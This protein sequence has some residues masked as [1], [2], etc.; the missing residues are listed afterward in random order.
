MVCDPS[1][2]NINIGTP[3]PSPFIP[4]L[5][6]PFS[7]PKLPLPDVK[8]PPGIPEDIIDLV[9]RIVALFPQG[10]KLV[11]NADKFMK[12]VWEA[13]AKIFDQIAP[14]LAFYKFIQALLNIILCIIDVI[15]ALFSPWATMKAVKRM[16][17]Q[18]LPD[19]LSLFP[20][21]ALLV[22]ILALILLLIEIIEYLIATI[23][24]YINQIIENIKILTRAIQ[25]HDADST[26]A[27]INK[28]AYI[29]CMIEQLFAILLAF[30]AII[31]II[32]PLMGMFGRPVC[33]KG[34]SGEDSCCSEDFCPSFISNNPEGLY[35]K[36]GHL[37]YHTEILPNIPTDPLF[38]WMHDIDVPPQRP[39]R[40]QFVDDVVGT[41]DFADIII[42]SPE[43]GFTFWPE[44]E[45]Y[46]SDS[47]IVRVPYLLDMNI[48]INPASYG[49]PSDI[50][51]TRIFNIR[52]I[53]V[54]QKPAY[55]ATQWN[56]VV[57][58]GTGGT[59]ALMLCGGT[60]WEY[61]SDGY[62]QYFI[63]SNAATLETLITKTNPATAIPP[64]DDGYNFT[65]L[66]Y[67]LRWNHAVLIDKKL[68]GL[69][70]AP[71]MALE[72]AVFNAEFSD[73]RSVL[74]RV[75]DLPDIGTLSSDRTTGTGTLGCLARALTKFRTNLNEESALVFQAEM[76]ACLNSLKDD[77]S[78]YF[79]RGTLAA[80]DKF[81]DDFELD[82]EIQFVTNSIDVTV[83]LRDKTGTLLASNVPENIG[84]S[85]ASNIKATPTLG[86]VTDFYYDGYDSFK[87]ILTSEVA[88]IGKI[89]AY[90]NNEALSEVLNRDDDTMATEI[91]IRELSY[92]FVDHTTGMAGSSS[93][94][95]G[96]DSTRAIRFGNS[97]I[98][99]DS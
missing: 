93:I 40:W 31:A 58:S 26:I 77:A 88:G 33:S 98:S 74:D 24:A 96:D 29:L 78:D 13:I 99:G 68:I 75:G 54:K 44:S 60:V 89:T 80:S 17:K 36:T 76:Q 97:D 87:A 50:G 21:I 79:N 86:N 61:D 10:I 72:A 20:W 32:Q 95:A 1:K 64:T 82:P 3:G 16:F 27:A 28:L 63:G 66:N 19:F 55:Y 67:I 45:T 56:N 41:Y 92:E 52:D 47:N 85:L 90:V 25:V 14:F 9:E 15:C 83:R 2:N 22:M 5:G 30:A 51:G 12:S 42:P 4:G 91:A 11:P 38:T 53:I 35:T 94:G 37:I 73:T 65:A 39:E 48:S 23:L 46:T 59:G 6:I 57:P 7:I 81:S 49:N 34:G 69:M 84:I 43:L 18:C 62:T 8:I 71:D 70:C